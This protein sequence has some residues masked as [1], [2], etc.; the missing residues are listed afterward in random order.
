[1]ASLQ[2]AMR[3]QEAP[4][5]LRRVKEALVSFRN[6]DSGEVKT[7]FTRRDVRT[8]DFKIDLDEWDF[9]NRL[10]RF[11]EDQSVAAAE[12]GGARGRAIGFTMAMLQRR[13]A[14]SVY[15]VRRTLERMKKRRE[16]ILADPARYRLEQIQRRVPDDFDDL[17]EQEQEA[18]LAELEEVVLDVDPETLRD[19][20]VQ[21][22]LLVEQACHLETREV[23]S[24]LLKLR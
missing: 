15:A 3:R 16:K 18:I 13:F 7:L 12:E 14:S 9:Y 10:T 6:P 4:F 20:I 2:E 17:T 23:E 22:G 5:Y 1:V 8:I 21:L 24:K 11:V 19:E